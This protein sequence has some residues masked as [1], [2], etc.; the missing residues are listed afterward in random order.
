MS[1]WDF[2]ED[3]AE[4]GFYGSCSGRARQRRR[5]PHGSQKK[6]S[7]LHRK[8]LT[9]RITRGGPWLRRG[10]WGAE[11]WKSDRQDSI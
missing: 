4:V 10:C 9:L 11:S 1:D 6:A 2:P 5:V 3:D 8:L 7:S